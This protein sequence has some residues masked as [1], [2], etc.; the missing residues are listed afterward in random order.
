MPLWISSMPDWTIIRNSIIYQLHNGAVATFT[1]VT[2]PQSILYR[3]YAY[4]NAP[5]HPISSFQCPTAYAGQLSASQNTLVHGVFLSELEQRYVADMGLSRHRQ[6]RPFCDSRQKTIRQREDRKFLP[7]L[8]HSPL[9]H[10]TR[11]STAER[12]RIRPILA[13]NK[14][15]KHSRPTAKNASLQHHRRHRTKGCRNATS[16]YR[17]FAADGRRMCY[18]RIC[19]Q[20]TRRMAYA[21]VVARLPSLDR[22]EGCLL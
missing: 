12:E 3:T 13:N 1:I 19:R 2:A 17:M 10:S 11:S 5:P 8:R 14:S 18:R 9:R 15:H 4:R 20:N 16:R 22:V 21:F 6:Q 7:P